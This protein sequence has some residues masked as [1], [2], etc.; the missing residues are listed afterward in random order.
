MEFIGFS[1][2]A[3]LLWLCALVGVI[4]VSTPELGHFVS[5]LRCWFINILLG[6]ELALLVAESDL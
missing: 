5:R 4:G 2:E 6:N 3:W 1:I